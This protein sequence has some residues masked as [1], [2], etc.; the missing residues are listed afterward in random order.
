MVQI[1]ECVRSPTSFLAI[2]F[3]RPST[4]H[5]TDVPVQGDIYDFGISDTDVDAG[6]RYLQ[7]RYFAEIRKSIFGIMM[8]DTD[9]DKLRT[10][11]SAELCFVAVLLCL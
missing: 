8:T 2:H 11:V 4:F 5:R 6:I 10:H 9:V 7:F 1:A 3:P